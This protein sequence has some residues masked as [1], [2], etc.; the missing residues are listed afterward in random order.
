MFPFCFSIYPAPSNPAGVEQPNNCTYSSPV[1][2]GYDLNTGVWQ[3]EVCFLFA[4]F[5]PAPSN[6]GGAEQPNNC[7]Y[8]SP[9]AIGYDLNT[10]VWSVKCVCFLSIS[11]SRAFEPSGAIGYDLNTGVW[12]VK[13]VSFF[14][15]FLN[16]PRLRNL[17]GPS[18]PTAS[19]CLFV[20][21]DLLKTKHLS[22]SLND[23][24]VGRP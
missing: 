8:S 24:P 12:S 2:I 9:V 21:K 16:I 18:N 4:F 23:S 1:A 7:T 3:C 13:R 19:S 15:F 20:D 6:P 14:A 10:G 17:P 22:L 11:L 5:Y